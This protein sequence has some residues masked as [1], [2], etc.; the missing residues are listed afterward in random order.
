MF[1]VLYV[2]M[3]EKVEKSWIGIE[4]N[5]RECVERGEKNFGYV[6]EGYVLNF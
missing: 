4:L 5:W 2:Q 1:K 3:V 6:E